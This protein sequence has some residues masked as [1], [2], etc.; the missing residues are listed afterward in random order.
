M[1]LPPNFG[2]AFDLSSLGK[3]PVSPTSPTIAAGKVV[4]KENLASD[5]VELSMTKPVILLCWTSR[6]PQ[7]L[8]T[9]AIL[10]KLNKE[11]LLALSLIALRN[12]KLSFLLLQ[13]YPLQYS[14]KMVP[15]FRE[16]LNQ[17]LDRN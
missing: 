12:L 15:A 11:E 16:N 8:D 4:T 6:A 9:L 7:S 2:Q 14:V 13:L 17:K 10:D 5:F 3:P 1:S